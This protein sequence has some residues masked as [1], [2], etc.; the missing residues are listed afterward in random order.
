MGDPVYLKVSPMKGEQRFEVKRKLA[1]RYVGPYSIIKKS[2]RVAYRVEL[3]FVDKSY[4]QC[5]SCLSI[6]EM[7]PLSRKKSCT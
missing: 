7:S 1:P 5:F 6:E 2:W 3:P 4:L